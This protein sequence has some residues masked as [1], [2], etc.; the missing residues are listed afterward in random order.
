M[1]K[2]GLVFLGVVMLAGAVWFLETATAPEPVAVVDNSPG[3]YS[4]LPVPVLLAADRAGQKVHLRWRSVPGALA[5]HLWRSPGVDG[6]IGV[7]FTGSDTTFTDIDGI[8]PDRRYC[9]Q[10]TT[11]DPEFDESGFSDQKCV[12]SHP[13]SR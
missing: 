1:K 4:G 11:I 10:L 8:F 6:D 7:I 2:A 3:E 5:Y 9:Y 13:D 12:D